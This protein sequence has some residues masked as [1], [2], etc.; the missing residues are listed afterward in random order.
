MLLCLKYVCFLIETF[1]FFKY[2]DAVKLIL[3]K[4]NKTVFINL[5]ISVVKI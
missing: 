1:E 2:S 4:F 5:I 3:N